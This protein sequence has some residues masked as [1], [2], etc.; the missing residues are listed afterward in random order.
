MTPIATAQ[1]NVITW[2]GNGGNNLWSTPGNWSTNKVPTIY[3]GVVII[4][5]GVT[6]QV[7]IKNTPIRLQCDGNLS[8]DNN[9][10]FSLTDGSYIKGKLT[11]NG[12]ISFNKGTFTFSGGAQGYPAHTI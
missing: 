5:E 7:D 2:T 8:V 3:E 11:N 1:T 12:T 9:V 6:L 10:I 4:P